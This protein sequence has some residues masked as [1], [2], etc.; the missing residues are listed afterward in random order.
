MNDLTKNTITTLEVSEM[1]ETEHWKLLRKLDG[2]KKSNGIIKILTDNNFVVSAMRQ[3]RKFKKESLE[4][5]VWTDRILTKEERR[6]YKKDHPGKRLS[7][8]L[9]YPNFM[10][11][12]IVFW[13]LMHTITILML[14]CKL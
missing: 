10:D 7:F 1:M 6:N 8:A 4:V 3:R 13:L 9:R 5:I 2:D 11:D 14:V 12:L